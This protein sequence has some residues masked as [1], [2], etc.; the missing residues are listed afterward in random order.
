MS[1]YLKSPNF[2][3][4][5][6]SIPASPSDGAEGGYQKSMLLS[7]PITWTQYI[8]MSGTTLDTSNT[9]FN[10]SS[11]ALNFENTEYANT[12]LAEVASATVE[13]IDVTS[14]IA[15]AIHGE[16]IAYF[17]DVTVANQYPIA[18]SLFNLQFTIPSGSN[19]GKK[20]SAS[21]AG[22]RKVMVPPLV[23]STYGGMGKYLVDKCTGIRKF[24]CSVGKFSAATS[25][26]ARF[27][28]KVTINMKFYRIDWS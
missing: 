17:D 21:P 20:V 4:A 2:L 18:H 3:N 6:I 16:C 25:S 28:M 14:K 8:R 15:T 27:G 11:T 22:S 7:T 1:S 10:Q 13:I 23:I 12:L 9:S 26:S 19:V 5:F 24:G